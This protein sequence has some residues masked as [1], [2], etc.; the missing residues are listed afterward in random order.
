MPTA[1]DSH[2]PEP[3]AEDRPGNR[4]RGRREVQRGADHDHG[5]TGP[6]ISGP[7]IKFAYPDRCAA[8]PVGKHKVWFKAAAP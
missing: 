6:T 3:E 4:H 7:L 8:M 5:R 1:A 2:E